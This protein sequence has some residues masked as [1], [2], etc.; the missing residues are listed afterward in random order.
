M[1][2]NIYT[3]NHGK[4]YGI[5][6]YLVF[7]ESLFKSRG[8]DVAVSE[9]LV[10]S[11][12]NI[13]ID[14]FTN[15]IRN[16]EISDFRQTHPKT[17][18]Y[19]LL[20]EF[21]ESRLL[22]V[23][24]N[25]F[26][27][28]FDAAA[29]ATLN[30][31]ARLIRK[32]F[33]RPTFW[34]WMLALL[35]SPLMALYALLYRLRHPRDSGMRNFIRNRIRPLAYLH[36]RYLG[37]EKM[38]GIADGFILAHDMIAP[39]I[40]RLAPGKPVLGTIYPEIDVEKI[41]KSIFSGK[42]LFLEITGSITPYRQH[43]IEKINTHILLMGVK[44]IFELCTV[45]PFS[46]NSRPDIP[47]GAYALHPPQSR[48]WKYCSP[49]R[50]YRSLQFDNCMPVLTK[51]FQQHPIENLCLVFQEDGESIYS[52]YRYYRSPELLL[53]EI[54]P[55]MTEYMHAANKNNDALANATLSTTG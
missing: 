30:V 37:L 3:A 1:L 31:Y 26:G 16:R 5:E 47:R 6:D 38:I 32:E 54:G 8:H 20:T 2:I 27:G 34:H 7:L 11:A 10:P 23:S 18:I 45:I 24:F 33:L 17:K 44:G 51:N 53:R 4:L 48:H 19:F 49:T 22:L 36:L 21:I 29:I 15:Q 40:A 39:G 12:I 46:S 13:V 9:E 28:L 50:I 41:R 52:L 55:R 25:F 42:K 43:W 14:E 35:Y